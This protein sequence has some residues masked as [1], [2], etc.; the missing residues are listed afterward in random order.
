MMI[1]ITLKMK[2]I[3]KMDKRLH[4]IIKIL[5]KIMIILTFNNYINLGDAVEKA[6]QTKMIQFW[7]VV[8]EAE[9]EDREEEG[10]KILQMQG[11]EEEGANFKIYR[12]IDLRKISS[13]I[14]IL[15]M[16]NIFQ[17]I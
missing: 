9:Q 5:I 14:K 6:E 8:E 4:R 16:E 2:M 17:T 3:F 11:Q 7:K 12:M 13:K 1:S 10:L 15:K